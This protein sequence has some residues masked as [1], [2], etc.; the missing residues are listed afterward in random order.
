MP[1]AV[2]GRLLRLRDTGKL[3]RIGACGCLVAIL[4]GACANGDAEEA[5]I[6]ETREATRGAI[7]PGV[8]ATNIVEEYF[9]PT[10]TPG[11][12]ETPLPTLA[13]LNLSSGV[14]ANNQ[15]TNEM[16]SVRQGATFYAVAQIYHLRAG[17]TITAVWTRDDG[18]EIDR[19]SVPVSKDSSGE[20]VPFQLSAAGVGGGTYAVYIYV[21]NVLLNSLVFD[22]N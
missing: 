3:V 1:L 16:E 2:T 5:H 13:A 7:L 19:V 22:V 14:G 10:A 20:W 12:T 21:D 6:A 8:Q 4:L 18:T 9:P 15:P 11:A 17:E